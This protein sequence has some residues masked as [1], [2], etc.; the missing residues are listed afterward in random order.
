VIDVDLELGDWKSAGLS[1]DIPRSYDPASVKILLETQGRVL[2][3]GSLVGCVEIALP[4]YEV[5][6]H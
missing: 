3:E 4:E 6:L 1:T 5:R 2:V